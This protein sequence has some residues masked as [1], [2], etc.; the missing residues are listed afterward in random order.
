MTYEH[1]G[2]LYRVFRPNTTRHPVDGTDPNAHGQF[3]R[4][5]GP[6]RVEHFEGE[7]HAVLE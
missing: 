2:H 1:P 7:P 4:P 3:V 6:A 5:H